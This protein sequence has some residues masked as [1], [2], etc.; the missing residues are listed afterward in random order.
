MAVDL[1]N[2]V[3]EKQVRLIC[4]WMRV[5]FIHGVMNTDNMTISGETIDYGPCAFMDHYDPNT[6]F[7]SID[8]NGRYAYFNQPNIAKWNLERSAETLLPLIDKDS[9]KAIELA[10]KCLKKFEENFKKSWLRMMKNKI[11]ISKD[12]P[13][14]EKLILELL[15]WMHKIKADYTNT[16]CHLMNRLKERKKV[17]D[18]NDFRNWKQKWEQRRKS[19]DISLKDSFDLMYKTN[20]IVIPRNHLVEEAIQDATEKNDYSKT[21]NLIEIL[22]SPYNFLKK[23]DFFQSEPDLKNDKYVTYC[24]T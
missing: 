9:K 4:D 11:G 13:S 17:Y 15:S 1:L 8:V 14:D 2:E 22:K 24:G 6:V 21:L 3:Q 23:S 5:G 7:S 10:E 16:F 19:D 20:P 18:N 12:D